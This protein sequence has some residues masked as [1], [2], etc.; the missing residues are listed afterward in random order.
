MKY[1]HLIILDFEANCIDRTFDPTEKMKVQEITEFPCVVLNL[2]TKEIDRSKTFHHYCSIDEKLTNFATHLTGITEKN[3]MCANSF[4]HVLKQHRQ[5]MIDNNFMDEEENVNVLFVTCG[6][7]D[8]NTMLPNQCK[9]S[10]IQPPKYFK[11]WCNVKT[12]YQQFYS[13]KSR[14]MTNML[15]ELCIELEGRHH[16]GI[17]DSYNIAKIC[18]TMIRDGVQFKATN[19]I[20]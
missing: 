10:K 20:F 17:D 8:L 4:R 5:W 13:R 15:T 3:T 6:N 12:L 19:H 2:N 11:E 9:Y 7:W 18:K 14:G 1:T 16:S